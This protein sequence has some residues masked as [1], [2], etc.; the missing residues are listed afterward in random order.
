MALPVRIKSKDQLVE[1][2]LRKLGSPAVNIEMTAEQLDD[3]IEDTLEEFLPRAYSGTLERYIGLTLTRNVQDYRLPDSVFAVLGLF[4]NNIGDYTV[5]TTDMFS[6][7]QYI[8][9]DIFGGNLK[10]V[11]LLS[12]TMTQQFIETMGVIFSKRI[13][14]DFNSNTRILHLHEPPKSD[15]KTVMHL[16]MILEREVDPFTAEELTNIYDNKWVKRMAVEKA[17]YQ[18]GINLMKYNGSVLPNGMSLNSEGIRNL[19]ETNMEKLMDELHNEWELPVDFM[20][21]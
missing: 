18:W 16:Y 7:N 12:Y 13:T 2:M 11:D 1:Y 21:G 19:A 4:N 3:A 10:N 14:F 15:T 5:S 17:R 20:I 6:A 9:A 8:A